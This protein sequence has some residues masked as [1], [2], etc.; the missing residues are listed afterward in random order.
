MLRLR[1]SDPTND[2]MRELYDLRDDERAYE[3]HDPHGAAYPVCVRP[4]TNAA[5]SDG[6]AGAWLCVADGPND[7]GLSRDPGAQWGDDPEVWIH[8]SR[9][10]R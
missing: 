9:I 5:Y 10:D 8:L 3:T 4:V 7:R 2:K 1:Q 6:F